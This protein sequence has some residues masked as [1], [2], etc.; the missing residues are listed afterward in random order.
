MRCRFC[1]HLIPPTHNRCPACGRTVDAA[2]GDYTQ[3]FSKR[4]VDRHHVVA[5]L[6]YL[7]ILVLIPLIFAR[8]S[9]YSRFHAN[10]GL[11]LTIITAAYTLVTRIFVT[12]LDILFGGVYAAIPTT[13]STI[14]S[15]GSVFF[16][17][18]L[19]LG[20]SNA[21]NGRAKELP[22]I[23]RIRFIV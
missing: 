4:D 13:L 14:F 5:V 19:L 21:A 9:Q 18:L 16:V 3:H 11:C 7:S 15:F 10:Q 2:H 17:V 1:E 20:M 22:L 12:F 8:R 6:S 23:G